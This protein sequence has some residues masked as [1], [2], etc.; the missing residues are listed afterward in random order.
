MLS[1]EL[2][3]TAI[4]YVLLLAAVALGWTL[5][6][7]YAQQSKKQDYP[8]WIPSVDFLLAESNDSALE[9]LLK[10]D[11]L[12]D[13]SIDLLLKLGK[14]LR[15]KGEL[16]RAMHLH[17]KLF[18]RA[19]LERS[20]LYAIQFELAC[21][22]SSAGLLDRAERIL[23]DLLEAKG[24]NRDKAALLLI[25]LLEEEGEWQNIIDL[26][27]EKMLPQGSRLSRRVAHA[28]CERAEH[29]VRQ[30]DFLTVQKL[31]KQALKIDSGC[32]RAH[33]VLGDLAYSQNEYREAIRCY[34]KAAEVDDSS[35]L[36]V[37]E[38]LSAAFKYSSDYSGLKQHLT[39]HWIKTGYVPALVAS[40]N[41]EGSDALPESAV[42][43]L[44]LE[45]KKRPS[46]QGFLALAEV[47]LSHRQQLDKSQLLQL[48]DILR[49][50]VASEPKFVCSSCGFKAKEPHWRCP[51]CKDWATIKAFVPQPVHQK[52]EL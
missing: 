27:R 45:L 6:Y 11:Q 2:F 7:R 42:S 52:P 14:S 34:L 9:N 16:D 44:L 8:D 43:E 32:A 28:A 23:R 1:A 40:M 31:C 13:D 41:V 35:V 37:V 12:D 5:G 33:I 4:L 21:D 36:S 49:G 46:N 17:Q 29:A 51:S 15:D 24:H 48:Y 47:V 50:I 39:E 20:A 25:E 19:D 18:A 30:S 22:Y 38:K 26:Y 10:I 3:D